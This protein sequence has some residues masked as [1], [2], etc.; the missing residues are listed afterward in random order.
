MSWQ[1]ENG[2]KGGCGGGGAGGGAV[3]DGG[4]SLIQVSPVTVTARRSFR[5]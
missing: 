5:W 2:A 3:G 4:R 1:L